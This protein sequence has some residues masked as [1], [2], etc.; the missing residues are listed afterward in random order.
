[1]STISFVYRLASEACIDGEG[2]GWASLAFPLSNT[3]RNRSGG[4]P[5]GLGKHKLSSDSTRKSKLQRT[6]ESR[7]EFGLHGKYFLPSLRPFTE[8][9]DLPPITLDYRS[10]DNSQL[11]AMD[12]VLEMPSLEFIPEDYDPHFLTGLEDLGSLQDITDVG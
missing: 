8:S 1:M 9:S 7:E 6:A 12:P 5:P 3:P 4:K 10:D 2:S 11:P